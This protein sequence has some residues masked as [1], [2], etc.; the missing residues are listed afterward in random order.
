VRL[1]AFYGCMS[2]M[3]EKPLSIGVNLWYTVSGIIITCSYGG[4]VLAELL[5]S[6]NLSACFSVLGLAAFIVSFLLKGK[7]MRAILVINSIGNL[8]MVLSYLCVLNANGALSSVIGMVVAIVN[9]FFAAK[10]KKIPMWLLAIYAA[11]FISCNLMVWTSWVDLF[12]VAAGLAA[13]FMISAKTG[14]GYR[15]WSIVND[16]LW[17]I[18][19]VLRGSYGPLVTHGVLSGFSLLGIVLYDLKRKKEA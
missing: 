1:A 19:D 4:I 13:V 14:K 17:T 7:E 16:G 5:T 15:I 2:N 18:F 9:Y 10:K 3:E 12:A 6:E 8:L 11:G